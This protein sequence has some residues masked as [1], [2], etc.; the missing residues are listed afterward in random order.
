[1]TLGPVGETFAS[2]RAEQR[3]V[4]DPPF[5]P[6]WGGDMAIC[7]GSFFWIPDHRLAERGSVTASLHPKACR[8]FSVIILPISATTQMPIHFFD[9]LIQTQ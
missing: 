4:I 9:F 7:R 5:Q 3:H 8:I 2:S 6:A 1:M